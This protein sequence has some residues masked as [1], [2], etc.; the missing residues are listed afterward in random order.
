MHE[1]V[2]KPASIQRAKM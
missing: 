2:S 1:I